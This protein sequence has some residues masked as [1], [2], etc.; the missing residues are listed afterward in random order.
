[1]RSRAM[2]RKAERLK[3]RAVETVRTARPSR[4]A[5]ADPLRKRGYKVVAVS[6]YSDQA[7]SVEQALRSLTEAGYPKANRSLVV[8]RAVQLLAEEIE[9]MNP[10]EILRFFGQGTRAK[11]L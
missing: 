1:M 6:L 7:E 8:Q 2:T 11:A 5:E 4:T 10:D 9:G 3:R